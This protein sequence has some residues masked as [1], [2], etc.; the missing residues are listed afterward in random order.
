MVIPIKFTNSSSDYDL[1]RLE[2]AFN[3]SSNDTGWYSLK[4]YYETVSY[5]NLR[6]NANILAPFETGEKY[7][8]SAASNS[9][10]KYIVNALKYY[11]D[12]IDYSV[13]DQN[14]DGKLDAVYFIYLAPY[15]STGYSDLWWAYCTEQNGYTDYSFDG[16][17][18]DWYMWASFE[19][20][21]EAIYAY[22][23][24]SG[25]FVESKSIYVDINCETIIHETGHLL[26]L[27]DY[28][29][30][31][32]DNGVKGG[33]GSFNMM[34][35]NQGDQDPFSKAILGWL[36]P[37]VIT[38]SDYEK[39][40]KSF[41][42][43]G[44]AIIISK[45]GS[46]SFFDDELY[47]IVYYTPTGVNE[48]KKDCDCGLPS[49]SGFAIY[50]IDST[51]VSKEYLDSANYALNSLEIFKYNNG[52]ASRK[53]IDLVLATGSDAID[54]EDYYV[55]TDDDLFK[56][57]SSINSLTWYDGSSLGCTISFSDYSNQTAKVTIDFE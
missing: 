17:E 53:L 38:Y 5:G 30:Y 21:D 12:T 34:D 52:G 22:Y 25:K 57:G 16:L 13:Y 45:N 54:T 6:F 24:N 33:L 4:S 46:G 2:K 48:L 28:Y 36:S 18:F 7:R 1:S 44:D 41:T 20:F 35:C 8:S 10:L 51:I 56:N 50:H 27:D 39:E 40:V 55:V 47:I 3:G 9:D 14:E 43:N 23:D 31:D 26:G 15:D 29:D 37:T 49:V 11:D 42:D 32:M 19:F